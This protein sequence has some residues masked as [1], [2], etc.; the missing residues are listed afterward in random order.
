M[1]NIKSA[2]KRLKQS[3]RLREK[4]R[5]VKRAL[6]TECKKVIAAVA[7][8]DVAKAESELSAAA[9]MFDQA[10][11]KKIIHR[12]ASSRVKSRLSARVKVLKGK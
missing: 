12:N 5:S 4:N 9:K 10:A 6:R 8:G 11:A 1:P 2:K 7:A 3:L